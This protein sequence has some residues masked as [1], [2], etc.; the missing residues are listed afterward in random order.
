[1]KKL[2][3][4]LLAGVMV[5]GV[6]GC[7]KSP[8]PDESGTE[9]TISSSIISGRYLHDVYT[10]KSC[11]D[12]GGRAVLISQ[13]YNP[14]VEPLEAQVRY[15]VKHLGQVMDTLE[16]TVT[17]DVADTEE[18]RMVWTAPEE[19][20][21][22]Y[23]V[24]VQVLQGEELLD[25]EMTAVDV[26]SDWNVFPRYGYLTKFG[27]R[28]YEETQELLTELSKYHINGLFYYDHIDRHDKPLAGTPDD[29]AESWTN[30]AN[31]EVYKSTIDDLIRVGHQLN[32][33]SFSYN[34]IFGAYPDY[35]SLGIQTEW[36]MFKDRTHTEFDFHP[37][38]TTWKASQ[39]YLMDPANKGWQDYYIQAYKD[40]LSVFDFDGIQ[41]DSLGARGYPIYDYNGNEL[42]LDLRYSELLD[43]MTKELD[44]KIIFN[45]VSEYGQEDVA[46]K[47]DLDIMFAEV[48]PWSHKS[49]NSLKDAVNNSRRLL[50]NDRGVVLPAYMDYDIKSNGG[51]FNLPGVLYTNAVIIASGG[52]HLELGDNGMLSSEYYPGTTLKMSRD[53]V[54]ATRNYYT[55]MTAYENVLRGGG[56]EEVTTRT[57]VNDEFCSL[58]GAQG[59]IW[60]FT[61]VKSEKNLEVLHLINL[62]D[63]ENLEWVDRN[64]TQ[65]APQVMTNVKVK[66]YVQKPAASVLVAS[67]DYQQGMMQEVP[68]TA[69]SDDKGDYIEFEIPHLEYWT[70]SVI[71]YA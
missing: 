34:L 53:L 70:M 64:G 20:F 6:T 22:G 61:K 46:S 16:K 24:E 10:D 58:A 19:D 50:G 14:G 1:M 63:V 30:L 15:T 39:I 5:L 60:S 2:L 55:F 54:K 56:L 4:G 38:P 45:A 48:W 42:Q 18:V 68:F 31:Q 13:V 7:E 40:F 27:R 8:S 66:Q 62:Q 17:I 65:T 36:G 32:M 21:T 67:P 44:T 57:Y 52:Q 25:Y 47:V 28:S 35:E 33:K 49:Y 26:S 23:S 9:G 11:Y 3:A 43:R 71:Q 59:E 12:P 69:G 29:P 37:L 51:E 41:V